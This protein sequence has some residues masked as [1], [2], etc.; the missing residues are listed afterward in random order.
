MHPPD[1]G[2]NRRL[3][4]KRVFVV[5]VLL[6]AAMGLYAGG[7]TEEPMVPKG[8]VT[9]PIT[10]QIWYS[11]GAA[12]SA[13][14]EEIIADFNAENDLITVEGSYQGGY[15]AT[16]EKLLAAYI[17]N[18]PPVLSQLEQSLVGAF[19]ANDALVPLEDFI[20][21]EPDFDR[22]DFFP[23]LLAGATY[24]GKLYGFP[25]NV[26]TPVV[27]VNRDM[28][29]A[30]GLDPDKAPA[31]WN[32]VY[33]I[34]KQLANPDGP[35]YG[36]RVYNSGWIMDSLFHQFGG[37]IFN[38]DE[39]K[40]L[41]NSPQIKEAMGFWQ[42][43]VADGSAVYQGGGDGSNM[44]AAGQIGLSLRSTGSI[45]W[46]HD[47]VTYDWG[48]VPFALGPNPAV[49]LGGGNV[50][51]VKRTSEQEQIAAWDF[52]KYLTTTENQIRWSL[53][54]GYMVSR[55]SAFNSPEIQQIFK[56]DP[57]YR[58]TYDQIQYSFPRPKVEAWPEIE[59]II[60]EAMTRIVLQGESVDILDQAASDIDELL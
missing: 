29:R 31:N 21:A 23:E 1:G 22:A 36:V 27:Y 11:L 16:Q 40:C 48:V 2:T 6:L 30:A 7:G 13:P 42:R 60:E 37:T 18:D 12:Y 52:L 3:H 20:A 38:D 50:Y 51:M 24:S 39:T 45:Q 17:A 44:D 19:V 47:N 53:A 34:S 26:S 33:Q 28:F 59:D 25:I 9:E 14:L 10:I 5:L 54:T 4:M 46:Y 56:D 15:A 58:V 55:K 35:I 43:M 8:E 49:S 32:D 57:R 41:I